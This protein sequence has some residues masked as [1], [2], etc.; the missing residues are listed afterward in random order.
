[1]ILEILGKVGFDWPVALANLINFLIIYLILRRFAFGPIQKTITERQ[2]KIQKGL[3]DAKEADIKLQKAETSKE[4]M[5]IEARKEAHSVTTKA[6]EQSAEII[7]KAKADAEL[8]AAKIKEDAAKFLEKEEQKMKENITAETS[9]LVAKA[10]TKTL[11]D[12]IDP[13]TDKAVVSGMLKKLS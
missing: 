6:S 12:S 10:L 5:L 2:N 13:N 7:K 1:M 8:D 9:K 11:E 3:E 4:E